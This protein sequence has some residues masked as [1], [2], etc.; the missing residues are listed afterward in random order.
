MLI[1]HFDGP[2][3]TVIGSIVVAIITAAVTIIT[4]RKKA[5]VDIQNVVNSGFELLV[6]TLKEQAMEREA[7][8]SELTRAIEA[9]TDRCA[10]LVSF[11]ERSGMPDPTV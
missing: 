3:I 2:A 5:T 8:I 1:K 4:T 10:R 6:K 9:C 11:I 7:K